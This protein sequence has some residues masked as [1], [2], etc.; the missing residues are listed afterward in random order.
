MKTNIVRFALISAI[1]VVA[2]IV[3][4]GILFAQSTPGPMAPATPKEPPPSAQPKDQPS[5]PPN[6][7]L[8]GN[9]KLNTDDSDDGRKKMQQSQG[10]HGG[11]SGGG[12]YPGGGG[13][14]GGMH[15]G[16]YGGGRPSDEDREKM[17]ELL[18]PSDSLNV[19]KKDNELDV[20]DAQDHKLIFFTDGRKTEK[21][22]DD[23]TQ[24]IPAEWKSGDLVSKE[25]GLRGG[26]LSRT[27]ELGPEGH[28]LYE[29]IRM[30]SMRSN[31]TIVIRYVYDLVPAAK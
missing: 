8:S 13:G 1:L 14:G 18:E 30:D 22:K 4:P 20:T 29:T 11:H 27:F 2:A 6:T 12:G 31:S 19:V 25:K 5:L 7:T 9:W 17:Q 10:G 21:S 24:Q 23:S 15:G 26:K 3:S 28:Q 16:G